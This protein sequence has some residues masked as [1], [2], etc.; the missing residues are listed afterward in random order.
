MTQKDDGGPAFPPTF[1]LSGEIGTGMSKREWYA[2]MAL[3]GMAG[4]TTRA[5]Y[6]EGYGVQ[7]IKAAMVRQAFG[8]ADAMIEASK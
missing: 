7:E 3:A 1:G 4:T 5:M 2:G 6:E 8:I